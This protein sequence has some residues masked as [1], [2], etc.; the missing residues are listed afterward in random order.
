MRLWPSA[1]QST[2]WTA[3]REAMV[4]TQIARRGVRDP[5]VLKAM[6]ATPRHLFVPEALR[7]MAYNDQPLPIGK[8]QT[9]SQPFIVG[10]MTDL[11]GVTRQ[12]KVLEI[13][14]GSGYQA[15]ILSQLSARVCSIEV[16][17]ELAREAAERLKALGYANVTVRHGDGYLGWPEEA[18]FDRIIIT[19]APPEMPQELVRQLKN[20]GRLVA[21]V[22]REWQELVVLDKDAAGRIHERREYPVVFVPMVPARN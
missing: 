19:A 21:P 16:V 10:S 20:G 4:E 7:R 13:G 17:E 5:A 2:D 6:R 14:T 22:G 3:E 8:G 1:E 18:P 11:L 15:A 12:H 9:I